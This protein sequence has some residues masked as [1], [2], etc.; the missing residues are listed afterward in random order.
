[1]NLGRNSSF[2]RERY[3]YGFQNQEKDDEVKGEGN[4]VNYKYRMHDPRLGRFFA[5]DPLASKFAWNS[6]YAFSENRV[7]D[8]NEIEGKEWSKMTTYNPLERCFNIEFTVKIK[9][10]NSS[11]LENEQVKVLMD[12]TRLYAG[13]IFNQFD[14]AK[15]INYS[16]KLEYEIVN[17]CSEISPES[18]FYVQLYDQPWNKKFGAGLVGGETVSLSD[19]PDNTQV[20]M[21]G[22]MAT[23]ANKKTGVLTPATLAQFAQTFLHELGHTGG[24][25]HPWDELN[26]VQDVD[27]KNPN[28]SPDVI[29]F[30]LMNSNVW[31]QN[32]PYDIPYS[33][34]Y[35]PTVTFG[36]LEEIQRE[37]GAEQY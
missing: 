23:R 30:N 12:D 18:D 16:I 22:T 24:L 33:Y 5:V 20:N 37:V 35:T 19:A 17:N 10:L 36:Q 34:E 28:I 14:E 21:F 6:P 8:G 4:S 11:S 29:K 25:R 1:M 13:K 15:R 7:I 27:I 26:T 2:L 9:V 31:E 32:S 3:R